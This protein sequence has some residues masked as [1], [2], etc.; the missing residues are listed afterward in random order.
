MLD[1]MWFILFL[2]VLRLIYKLLHCIY[3]VIEITTQL[4]YIINKK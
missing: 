3:S 2:T 4:C 1:A